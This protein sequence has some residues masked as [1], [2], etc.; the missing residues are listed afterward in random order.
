MVDL[1]AF[2]IMKMDMKFQMDVYKYFAG[3]SETCALDSDGSNALVLIIAGL[4]IHLGTSFTTVSVKDCSFCGLDENK[5]V[6]CWGVNELVGLE[7]DDDG[8]DKAVDC[9]DRVG[10]LSPLTMM[11]MVTVVVM[12]IGMIRMPL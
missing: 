1:I 11:V 3:S 2:G 10:T 9:N 4:K 6:T 8:Y 7:D 12:E 5:D